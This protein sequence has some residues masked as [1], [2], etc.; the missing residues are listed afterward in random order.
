VDK[1]Q[2]LLREFAQLNGKRTG[3]GVT[4]LEYLRWLDLG[5]RLARMF[6]DRP[7]VG[8][9]GPTRVVVE[10]ATRERIKEAVMFNVRPIGLFINTPFAPET[11]TDFELRVRLL[12]TGEEFSSPV[13]VVSENVGPQFST[14]RLGMGVRFTTAEN[15]L[16]SFLDAL[17]GVG[18][19]GAGADALSA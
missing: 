15:D 8:R 17:C 2:D 3:E 5:E 4:P 19:D 7:P 13:E 6:P 1:P 16:R 14:D 12:E 11:G 9:R 18:S 10:F